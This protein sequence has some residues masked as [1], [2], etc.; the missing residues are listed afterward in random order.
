MPGMRRLIVRRGGVRIGEL[1]REV[2]LQRL[3]DLAR[4][5]VRQLPVGRTGIERQLVAVGAAV[6]HRDRREVLAVRL[7]PVAVGAVE[8]LA[9]AAAQDTIGVEMLAVRELHVRLLDGF[10]ERGDLGFP[11]E[12]EARAHLRGRRLEQL[13]LEFGMVSGAEAAD[14]LDV[15]LAELLVRGLV[16]VDAHR[17]R[18]VHQE[19]GRLIVLAMT[20]RAALR[21]P[22]LRQR[23]VLRRDV[24]M[25]RLVAAQARFV[26]HPDKRLLVA[27]VAAD[28]RRLL[29]GR[30]QRAA[31]P[32]FVAGHPGG[33]ARSARCMTITL[34]GRTTPTSRTIATSIH[35]AG[36]FDIHV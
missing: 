1:A 20:G 32:E 21:R 29:M 7:D 9:V 5:A 22:K 14:R 6:L 35:A 3:H 25:N 33:T 18:A 8:R 15:Q 34:I 19:A 12:L 27:R 30:T 4:L 11:F 16:A 10:V 24:I 2:V 26:L 13:R 17:V 28:T 36:R 23:Q 31:V